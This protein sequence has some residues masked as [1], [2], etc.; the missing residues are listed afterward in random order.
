MGLKPHTLQLQPT[1]LFWCCIFLTMHVLLVHK[2]MPHVMVL[3]T[4]YPPILA[5]PA[6]ESEVQFV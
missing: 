6:K 5:N 1:P 4:H 2:A 3:V